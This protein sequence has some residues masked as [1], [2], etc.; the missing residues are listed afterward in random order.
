MNTWV[1]YL[2]SFIYSING[3]PQVS[4]TDLITVAKAMGGLELP[5]WE[6]MERVKF[7][8]EQCRAE[9]KFAV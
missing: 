1:I 9:D 4:V 2:I 8:S 7:R 3:Y 5:S 6:G